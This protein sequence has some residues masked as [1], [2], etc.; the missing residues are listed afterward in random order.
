MK[1]QIEYIRT[2]AF[3]ITIFCLYFPLTAQVSN[4]RPPAF[5]LVTHDPYFSIWSP[6]E[7][8]TDI[9]TVHW[10]QKP[11]PIR[12]VARI[13]GEAYR[14]MG[15]SPGFGAAAKSTGTTTAPPTDIFP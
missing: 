7:I 5:P 3:L 14:L 15:R 8:P 10:T 1:K 9:E 4:F 13:D 12:I 6:G 11:N 2:A